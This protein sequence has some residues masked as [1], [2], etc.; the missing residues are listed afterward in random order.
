MVLQIYSYAK[1][2]FLNPDEYLK[3]VGHVLLVE[4]VEADELV[5]LAEDVDWL[6]QLLGAQGDR[7]R[8][9]LET[10]V[11]DRGPML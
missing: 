9:K 8:T 10:G 7:V 4:R 2:R 1:S 6:V 5:A 11:D 3:L